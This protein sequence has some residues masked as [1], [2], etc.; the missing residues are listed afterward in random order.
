MEKIGIFLLVLL[1]LTACS[2]QQPEVPLADATLELTSP[3]FS[4][5]EAIPAVFTCSGDDISPE[6][7]WTAPPE[8]TLTFALIMDDPDAPSGTWVHW[9]LYD[10]PQSLRGLP[11]NYAPEPGVTAGSNSW[12]EQNYGGPCP[13]SG[14]H[15]YFFKLYALD[16]VLAAEPGLDKAGLL[17]LMEGHVLAQGELMGMYEKP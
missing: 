8:G 13:P 5:G 3:D 7:R 2:A 12:N 15:R 10:L 1:A 11:Q 14:Q 9:V 17:E 16:T 6:L 4:A